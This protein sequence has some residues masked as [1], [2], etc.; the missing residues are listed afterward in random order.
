VITE[1]RPQPDRNSS[2]IESMR[3]SFH[4]SDIKISWMHVRLHFCDTH[5]VL[6]CIRLI[7]YVGNIIYSLWISWHLQ[8]TCFD[9]SSIPNVFKIFIL[10]VKYIWRI[11]FKWHFLVRQMCLLCLFWFSSCSSFRNIVFVW[12]FTWIL[13]CCSLNFLNNFLFFYTL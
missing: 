11:I 9:P 5:Y 2:W 12:C 8:K 7:L 4:T 6:K 13:R 10:F 3:W 1:A